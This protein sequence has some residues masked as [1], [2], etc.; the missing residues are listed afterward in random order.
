[1]TKT[2][3]GIISSGGQVFVLKDTNNEPINFRVDQNEE[4]DSFK[5]TC[6]YTVNTLLLQRLR[7]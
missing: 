7:W 2:L 4:E 5:T 6:S 1:M 3:S